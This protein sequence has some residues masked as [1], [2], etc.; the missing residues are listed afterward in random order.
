MTETLTLKWGPDGLIPAVVQDVRTGQVLMQAYMNEE[1]LRLTLETGYAWYWSRSRQELWQKGG[2]SGH[3]QRVREIRTDCDGD[4]LLLLVEQEG[5]AC[6]EG[7]Y[8]CFTRRVD[9]SPKALI[10]TAFWPIQP[11]DT[12]PY[13][14]GS[15]LRELTAVLAERRAH[16]DPE[17][18]TS[19]LFRRGPDAYC[20]K[21]GEEA[22]EVV[23]AVK[24]R[25]R[26][27]L[28]FEVADLWF[29]SLV[30]LVDQG[31]SPA[32]VADQLASRR[33]RRREQQKEE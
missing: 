17:S 26:E 27:N 24:N 3:V 30:A 8:S 16:P 32:D 5:V 6:H 31:L 1:A 28:A 9:G 15:I 7:T 4:S 19:R 21:I 23:L 13:D 29:H 22:T 25:D 14:I 12:V 20:K 18:Y 11:D 10:D 33:G 2:T